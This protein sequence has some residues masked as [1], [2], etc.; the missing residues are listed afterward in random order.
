MIVALTSLSSRAV[1]RP[2][3]FV[4]QGLGEI[5]QEGKT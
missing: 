4:G 3:N 1:A 2:P 5:P